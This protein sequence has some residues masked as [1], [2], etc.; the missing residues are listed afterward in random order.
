MVIFTK[1]Q[2][3]EYYQ[4]YRRALHDDNASI[5]QEDLIILDVYVSNNSKQNLKIREAKMDRKL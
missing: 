5:P 2:G 4:S 3:Q 1:F